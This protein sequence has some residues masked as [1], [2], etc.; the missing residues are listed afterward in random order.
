MPAS[1]TLKGVVTSSDR[2]KMPFD[3][4]F[5]RILVAYDGSE[6]SRNA[7]EIAARMATML[8]GELTILVVVP[9]EIFPTLP[10]DTYS[11]VSMPTSADYFDR[12]MDIY[13]KALEEAEKYVADSCPQLNVETALKE[14]RPATVIVSEA[15]RMNADLIVIANRGLGGITGW[16]LGSTSHYVVDHCTKP[17]LVVK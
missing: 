1:K 10:A 15:E 2:S 17:V 8:R 5:S 14:G 12:S 4:V 9:P 16:L 11:D 13:K 6:S 7:L 3:P